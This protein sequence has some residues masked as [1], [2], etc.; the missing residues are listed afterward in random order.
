MTMF[1]QDNQNKYPTIANP[2]S[3]GGNVDFTQ[4]WASQIASYAG[5]NKIFTC[6]MD[7]NGPGYVSYGY[8]GLL[9][10]P[11]GNGI[12][13]TNVTNPSE[14]GM[15]V[16]ATSYKYPES[17]VLNW[18]LDNHAPGNTATVFVPR[19][20]Y[21][22]T[23]ADGHAASIGGTNSQNTDSLSS[24][25]H[26]AFFGAAGFGWITNAGAGQYEPIASNAA[27]RSSYDGTF[28][29]Q[30]DGGSFSIGGSTTCGPLWDAAC[31][32]WVAAGGSQPS[33]NYQGSNAYNV[34]DIGG[35]SSYNSACPTVIAKD[36]M[37][38]VI[39]NSSRLSLKSISPTQMGDIFTLANNDKIGGGNNVH[40][41]SRV[42]AAN[43]D[44]ETV[45]TPS[46]PFTDYGSGT[47]SFLAKFIKA[48]GGSSYNSVAY[49]P[50]GTGDPAGG[51]DPFDCTG[52]ALTACPAGF[53]ITTVASTAAVLAAV[54]AD[55]YG[56]GY[57]SVGE[58]D[59]TLV[60]IVP[61][62]INGVIQKYDRSNVENS[63][64]NDAG[65]YTLGSGGITATGANQWALTRHLYG[66]YNAGLG[67]DADA[68]QEF[69]AFVQS[70]QF[71]KSLIFHALFFTP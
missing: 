5:N 66:C 55:P 29:Q 36:G 22:L 28:D 26:D 49:L 50:D 20:S 51:Q 25:I 11:A 52:T 37:A 42:T 43:L 32:A 45:Q 54:S 2:T 24:P 21:N 14:V 35:R 7:T 1:A 60:T 63:T 53:A 44:T 12:R 57:C 9:L 6:P 34:Y 38:I 10:D 39:S 64:P 41:Y 27:T 69:F 70:T 30:T 16:D 67:G 65:V 46:G 40:V 18:A 58:A 62:N 3:I 17:G 48:N 13:T 23:Y 4:T 47:A 59:P 56:I 68:A 71:R 8:N 31:A 33:T 61:L 15:F 19:H